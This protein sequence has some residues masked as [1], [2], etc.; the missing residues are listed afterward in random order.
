M[1]LLTDGATQD[2]V[3][4]ELE[5]VELTPGMYYIYSKIVEVMNKKDPP[6]IRNSD[7]IDNGKCIF[8][9]EDGREIPEASVGAYASMLRTKG[10][11]IDDSKLMFH[12]RQNPKI[13]VV[14]KGKARS[15]KKDD[16]KASPPE[17]LSCKAGESSKPKGLTAT[18]KRTESTLP[19]G[20]KREIISTTILISLGNGGD[21]FGS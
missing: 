12:Y 18:A 15:K 9:Y 5:L 3:S 4:D 2:R 16:D 21:Q 13:R 17:T 8:T 19:N 11:F 7:L 1:T 20:V 6:I 14:I 10:A